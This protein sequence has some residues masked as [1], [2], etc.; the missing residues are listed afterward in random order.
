V[1]IA[2]EDLRL[3]QTKVFS[4]EAAVEFCENKSSTAIEVTECPWT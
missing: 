2:T 4:T 3:P 1:S